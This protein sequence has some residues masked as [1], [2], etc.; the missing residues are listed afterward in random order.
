VDTAERCAICR[1]LIIRFM[2]HIRAAGC[3]AAG[4]CSTCNSLAS[5]FRAHVREE[6]D[7]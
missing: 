2:I 6:H 4:A 3:G 1:Q 7:A 5:Q